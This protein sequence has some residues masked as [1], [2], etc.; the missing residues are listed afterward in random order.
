MLHSFFNCAEVS[1]HKLHKSTGYPLVQD[2]VVGG[3]GE[4]RGE[5]GKD[6]GYPYLSCLAFPGAVMRIER[7]FVPRFWFAAVTQGVDA[8]PAKRGPVVFDGAHGIG[9]PKLT[10]L[11]PKLA[12]YLDMSIRNGVEVGDHNTNV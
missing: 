5:L 1:F 11:A 2:R 3:G 8:A 9:A 10:L 7:Y 6:C 4:R 12:G